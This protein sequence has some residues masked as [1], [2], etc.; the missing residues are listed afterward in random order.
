MKHVLATYGAQDNSHRLLKCNDPQVNLPRELEGLTD[1][2]PGDISPGDIWWPSVGCGP[3]GEWWCIWWTIP[4][5]TATRAGMVRSEVALWRREHIGAVEDLSPALTE[6]AGGQTMAPAPQEHLIAVAE[7]ILSAQGHAVIICN[8]LEI[9][10]Q[11]IADVWRRLW[12]TARMHFSARLALNPPQSSEPNNLPWIFGTPACRAQ[13]WQQPFERIELANPYATAQL[14]RA[15]K[16]LAGQHDLILSE[17]LKEIPP[18]DSNLAHLKQAARVADN[19]ERLNIADDFNDALALLRTL[20]VMAPTNTVGVKFKKFACSKLLTY[21]PSLSSDQVEL[22]ANIDLSAVP[23]SKIL[24]EAFR[25]RLVDIVPVLSTEK[26]ITFLAKLQPGKAQIWWQTNIKSVIQRGLDSLDETW[27][28]AAIRWLAIPDI[29]V[30]IND[31]VKSDKDIERSLINIA[32]RE[33]WSPA[34]LN[35]IR[36]QAQKRKWSVLHAWC[37]VFSKL[38]VADT[39]VKQQ[40]FI[41]DASPGF[42]YL[43]HNLPSD[44]VVKTIVAGQDADLCRLA[45]QLTVQKPTLLSLIDVSKASSRLLW[46]THIQLCGEAWPESLQPEIHGNKLLEVVISGD[47][48]YNLIEAVGP[49]LIQAVVEHPRRKE[50]WTNLTVNESNKLL[51]LVANQL[52]SRIKSGQSIAQPE[53]ALLNKIVELL[54]SSRPSTKEILALITWNV[55]VREQELI[56]WMYYFSRLDWLENAVKIGQ[57]I[58]RHNWR[59]AA[60]KLIEIKQRNPEATPS[61]EVCKELLPIWD[62]LLQILSSPQNTEGSFSDYKSALIDG[63]A[64]IGSELAP[65]S[66]DEVWER[67]GGKRKE[68]ESKGTAFSRWH[69]AARV[70]ANGGKC[71]LADLIRVLRNDY[72]RNPQLREIEEVLGRF[73]SRR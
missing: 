63:V 27:S 13:Q 48:S 1:R 6:I 72:P 2:P 62:R 33:Q 19:L 16:F 9:W 38:S 18:N 41:G 34:Q 52:I 61:L 59:N 49:Y 25:S 54:R 69:N 45:A 23:D 10:P 66:L 53:P 28:C 47:D 70:A 50:L 3:V 43:I 51:P 73:K 55:P 57:V 4:D 65:E 36:K 14:N 20:I 67:A 5:L 42:E 46:A 39:F 8:A 35:Q 71:S 64:D 11:I 30:I 15:A 12:P 68:L 24:E 29:E 58:L 60:K 32:N 44:A 22:L 31:F 7:A 17:V 26:S 56:D 37:L 40:G 21:L